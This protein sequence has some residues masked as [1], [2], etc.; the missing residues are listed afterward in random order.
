MTLCKTTPAKIKKAS[1]L[2]GEHN[3]EVF[4]YLL[5]M[6]KEEIKKFEDEQIIY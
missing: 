2:L 3:A 4:G 1:P 5:G 6:R